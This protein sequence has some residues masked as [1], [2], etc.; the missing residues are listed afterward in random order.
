MKPDKNVFLSLN[1]HGAHRLIIKREVDIEISRHN[2]IVLF[3]SKNVS[4]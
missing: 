3:M 1:T 4:C 2:D